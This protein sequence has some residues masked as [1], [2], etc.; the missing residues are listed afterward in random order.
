MLETIKK[1]KW[2]FKVRLCQENM[3][4]GFMS[5]RA[6]PVTLKQKNWP[7]WFVEDMS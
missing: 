2:I 5:F 1:T 4:L 7:Y 3:C 6:L